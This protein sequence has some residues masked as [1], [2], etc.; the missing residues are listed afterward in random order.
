MQIRSHRF[1]TLEIPG[2]KIIQMERPILGFEHLT[3]FCLIE[4][5]ELAPLLWLQSLEDPQI[6]FPV[7]NPTVF[8]PH[9]RIEIN[10]NEIAELRVSRPESIETY[11]I[12]TLSDTPDKVSVNL[13]G[14][15]LINTENN[16]AKQLVMVNSDYHVRHLPFD[17]DR[18]SVTYGSRREEPVGV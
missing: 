9:Y 2:S 15:V 16:L 11:V 12:V 3:E 17:D 10:P 7:V 8:Y 18:A 5:E 6:A 4:K 14:P 13:Q 1:G